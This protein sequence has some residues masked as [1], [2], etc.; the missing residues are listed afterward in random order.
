MNELWFIPPSDLLGKMQDRDKGGLLSI[1]SAQSVGKGNAVFQAGS[2][3]KNV[4]ILKEGRV[5]IFALSASG[6]AILLWFCFPGE[7]FGLAEVPRG[8][9]RE[10]YA[11]A[12]SDSVVLS[13]P[14]GLFKEFLTGHPA[15]AMLVIDL[16]SCRLRTLGDMLVNLTADDV[17]TRL[18]K[19]LIRL[20]AR[21]GKRVRSNDIYLDIS[22]THQEIA[23]MI[24]TSRQTV[25]GIFGQLK[26][27][28]VVRIEK[29]CIH[30]PNR[31]LLERLLGARAEG[32]LAG[33][34]HGI[35]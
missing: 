5:K 14:C 35:A 1:A 29:H 30:I 6:K 20:T 34:A 4:Y 9:R 28:G 25:T 27:Q 11:E 17:A 22:L 10:V 2:P 15:A 19:L 13:V 24:G 31:E 7:I 18:I 12:C 33:C 21:Y 32:S 23:D 26:R 16:L 3:G 8:G